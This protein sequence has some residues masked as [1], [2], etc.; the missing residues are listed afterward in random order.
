MPSSK[1]DASTQSLI[2]RDFGAMNTTSSRQ[3][4]A[5]GGSLL[6]TGSV[7]GATDFAWL[8]NV[9][10][11]GP[12]NLTVVP[13]KTSKF[14]FSGE[15]CYASSSVTIL[16]IE[17]TIHATSAGNV[18][19]SVA[20]STSTTLVKAGLSTSG[21]TFAPW[22]NTYL[23]ILDPTNGLSKWDGTTWTLISASLIGLWVAVYAGSVWI[24]NGR[25]ITF[26]A[27]NSVSDYTVAD[28]GGSIVITDQGMRG[29]ITAMV[30]CV[31]WL[32]IIGPSCIVAINNVT[33]GTA[34]VRLTPVTNISST[35]GSNYPYG[36]FAWNGALVVVNGHGAWA[37]QGST[38]QQLSAPMNGFFSNIDFTQPI[39]AAV[40]AVYNVLCLLILCTYKPTSTIY[41][42][43]WMDAGGWFLANLG[44]LTSVT[45]TI[46]SNV[47]TAFGSDGTNVYELFNDTS[48]PISGKIITK[49]W[50]G[51]DPT[52][53]KRV[54]K[55][56]VEVQCP[57]VSAQTITVNQDVEGQASNTY[58]P[59][60]KVG[61]NWLRQS[62][63]NS[64]QYFGE[65]V[66]FSAANWTFEGFQFQFDWST[67]WPG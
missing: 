30:A 16:G 39:A 26:S 18:Y 60:P 43:C 40:G 17:Y 5:E 56:G 41:L 34:N 32:Y 61:Y 67:T 44:S 10:P 53:T 49:F 22:Q 57:T 24:A 20:G 31:D 21:L 2:F 42:M 63:S 3:G 54:K 59:S 66:T 29:S 37:Y 35:N 46:L 51:G 4:L 47:A 9:I 58:E 27:P 6:S 36:C 12:A 55:Y 48:T 28:G 62:C 19:A 65:T 23:L 14:S 64:G 8:E 38:P 13:N 15:T 45:F 7:A 52:T 33:L 50:D 1:P 25:T 11:I